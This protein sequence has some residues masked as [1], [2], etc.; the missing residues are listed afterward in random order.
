MRKENIKEYRTILVII[1][2]LTLFSLFV[3]LRGGKVMIKE[4][5]QDALLPQSDYVV[6]TEHGS[7]TVGKSSW[8]E[9]QHLFPQGKNLGNS[10]IYH[11]DDQPIFFTF[12]KKE[13]ILTDI[14]IQGG[15]LATYRGIRVGDSLEKLTTAYGSNYTTISTGEAGNVDVVYG[16]GNDIVFQVRGNLV[17]AIVLQHGITWPAT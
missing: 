2:L 9:V 10:T 8:E 17:N 16:R 1:V 11:P 12:S 14:H 13:N 4:A 7:L 15:S 3:S 5:G 6:Q